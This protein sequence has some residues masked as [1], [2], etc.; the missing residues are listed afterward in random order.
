M[1][2]AVL[3]RDA[4]SIRR[5]LP[6]LRK[7][8][9]T[10]PLLYVA[11]DAGGKPGP[12]RQAKL[13]QATLRFLLSQLPRA[14]CLRETWQ[15]L[16]TA[17]EM[18]RGSRPS[19]M[20]V[21]EFD[22]LFRTALKSTL[23]CIVRSAS[24]WQID[25]ND[26]AAVTGIAPR[27]RRDAAGDPS[28]AIDAAA[29]LDRRRPWQL[30][31]GSSR[32]SPERH[33]RPRPGTPIPF[34]PQAHFR[35]AQRASW[36]NNQI[37]TMASDVVQRYMKLWLTHSRSMRLSSVEE[38]AEA[39]V[40]K[41]VRTFVETYGADLFHAKLLTL[42]N[43]RT[44]L[45]AGIEGFLD[46]LDDTSDDLHP[47]KLLD[48]LYSGQ[49]DSEKAMTY[50]EM[51][52]ESV[53]DKFD[54]Y[55]EYN[56]TTT[57][58]DYGEKFYCLLD[59]LRAES[60]YE[61]DAWNLSP[62]GVCHELF[63]ECGRPCRR[64]GLGRGFSRTLRPRLPTSIS[65]GCGRS[66]K[67]TACGCHRSPIDSR[68][69]SSSRSPSIACGPSCPRSSVTRAWPDGIPAF[70]ALRAEIDEYLNTTNGSGIDVPAW[71]RTLEREIDRLLDDGS[72]SFEAVETGRFHPAAALSWNRL[73]MELQKWE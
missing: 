65:S 59:F 32:P 64:Q 41:H 62:I 4:G 18:E 54:R 69:S 11:L 71:L 25:P 10:K 22:Q 47:I 9:A 12:F 43:V 26:A 19:G 39:S 46:Y 49:I 63:S 33:R 14:G 13:L 53:V 66:K 68:S 24:R 73:Q 28:A 44:I 37:V 45:D 60:A 58:S 51:I 72:L 67:N 30:R 5:L 2:R 42:G 40:W 1:F 48:D 3:R 23:E 31:P 36:R 17:Y 21:S 56:T 20:V 70:A 6:S 7:Q 29:P 27:A 50:L 16:Q 35:T 57:H 52:Y 34:R 8:L 55:V 61:R 38:M 15:L